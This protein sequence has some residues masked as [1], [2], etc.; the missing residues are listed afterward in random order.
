MMDECNSGQLQFTSLGRRKVI[1]RFDGGHLA[2]DAD[3]LPLREVDSRLGL[4]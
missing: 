2:S 4:L 3:G 1:A